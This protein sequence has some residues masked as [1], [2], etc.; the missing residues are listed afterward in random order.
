LGGCLSMVLV[1]HD[2]HSRPFNTL[3]V[4][5]EKLQRIMT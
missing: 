5:L 1:P 2:D 3:S 4:S